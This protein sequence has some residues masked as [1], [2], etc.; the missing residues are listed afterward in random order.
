MEGLVIHIFARVP[1][2]GQTK[3]RLIPHLGSVQAAKLAHAMTHD[4]ID[5]V[6]ETSLP[7]RVALSGNA[8]HPWTGTLNC[9]WE[10]QVEGTL[11]QKLAYALRDGGIAIGTDTPTLPSGFLFEAHA[12]TA[13][14]VLAPAFDGGYTLVG[15][16]NA[17]DIFELVPWSSPETFARQHRRAL[18][19]GRSVRVLPFW[20][21]IDEPE[22]LAFLARH[23]GTLSDRVAPRTRAWL[24]GW[25]STEK[26]AAG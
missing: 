22:D 9:D 26:G 5:L 2:P 8:D 19:L 25:Q 24:A 20:Y 23:I 11:G 13:D 12:S 14:V 21:D 18:D 7:F 6:R 17:S 16:N 10:P 3:T 1:E 15:V 4:V